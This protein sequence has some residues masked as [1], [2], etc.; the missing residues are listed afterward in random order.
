MKQSIGG[1][2]A[3]G[4][5]GGA[6]EPTDRTVAKI[7]DAVVV[8]AAASGVARLKI[9]ARL[10]PT[11][12]GAHDFRAPALVEIDADGE[13]FAADYQDTAAVDSRQFT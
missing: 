7:L 1:L 3:A 12:V 2:V 6:A 11:Y 10:R 4:I 5:L 13:Q 8:E 9:D